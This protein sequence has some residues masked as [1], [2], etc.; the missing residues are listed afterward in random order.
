MTVEFAT[1]GFVAALS[2]DDGRELWRFWT[3]PEPGQPGSETWSGES[4]K[5]GCAPIWAHP[6]FD[7]DLNQIYLATGNPCPMWNGDARKGDNLYSNAI[8]ALNPDDGTLKWHFQVVPHD[9]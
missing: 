5:H 8:I 3:V 4:W 9:L 7:A 2:K 6:T 1:R